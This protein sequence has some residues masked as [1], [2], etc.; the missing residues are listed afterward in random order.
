M[1]NGIAVLLVSLLVAGCGDKQRHQQQ[2]ASADI[3]F[4]TRG[5]TRSGPVGRSEIT[6]IDAALSDSAEMPADSD[7]LPPSPPP[8]AIAGGAPKPAAP[9]VDAPAPAVNTAPTGAASS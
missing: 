7:M 2:S 8:E 9:V 4:D 6:S 3:P 5:E 1:K